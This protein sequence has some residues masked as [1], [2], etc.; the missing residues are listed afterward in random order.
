MSKSKL[1][2]SQEGL[3]KGPLEELWPDVLNV[4]TAKSFV[5]SAEQ[6]IREG[7]AQKVI[8]AES[9]GGNFYRDM[10]AFFEA[11]LLRLTLEANRYN[12]SQAARW[13]GITRATLRRKLRQHGISSAK[14]LSAD[15]KHANNEDDSSV[16]V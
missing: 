11:P 7:L 6:F 8:D 3:L 1:A 4:F 13:L 12:Q 5:S 14:K 15:S 2:E 16:Y 10:M 9:E